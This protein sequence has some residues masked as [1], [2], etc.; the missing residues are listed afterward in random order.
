MVTKK[1]RVGF[2]TKVLTQLLSHTPCNLTNLIQHAV[3]IDEM[4]QQIKEHTKGKT[5]T[6]TTSKGKASDQKAK[7]DNSKYK[8]SD[9]EQQE[10]VNGN[11][12][13]KCHKKWHT[14]KDCKGTRTVYSEVKKTSI[15]NVNA[16]GGP[17]P[18]ERAKRRLRSRR[19]KLERKRRLMRPTMRRILLTATE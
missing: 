12:C 19:S 14:S 8:L 5:S 6:S 7:P 9:A 13:F 16:R 10:Y 18:R 17:S 11:L 15:S 4:L 1:W 2:V 3:I